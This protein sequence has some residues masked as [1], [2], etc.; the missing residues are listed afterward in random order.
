MRDNQICANLSRRVRSIKKLGGLDMGT[1][2]DVR[3]NR[4]F[5]FLDSTPNSGMHGELSNK[6]KL[7]K[8]SGKI[9]I[10]CDMCER[11]YETYAAW[12]KRYSRHYCSVACRAAAMVTR[13]T[14][15]CEIC[16][17]QFLIQKC[18]E[19]AIKCCSK[20]CTKVLRLSADNRD[21]TGKFTKK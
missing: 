6:T 17:K 2:R 1:N 13:V 18:N 11:P 10:N 14:K 16:G 5:R 4:P 19:K 20:E 9:S 8:T 21:S 12:A 3:R 7:G 15:T